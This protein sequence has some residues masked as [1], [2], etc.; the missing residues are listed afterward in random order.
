MD[1]G[2]QGKRAIVT[3]A[4]R[5]IGRAIAS[6][7]A[8]EG[9]DVAI[10]A[11][12]KEAVDQTAAA[13]ARSGVKATGG[14]VDVADLAALRRWIGEAAE[15]LGGLDIFVANVSALAQGM[16]EDSWRK[17]FEIDVM[18]TVFGIEAALPLLEKSSAGSIVVVGSTAMA[19]VYGPTRSYAAV[20]AT[21][22]P[23]VKGLA[24]NLAAKNVRANVVSPGNVYFQGGVW[25]LVEQR[26]P[27]MFASMLARNPTGRMGTPE[28]VANAVVFLASP[29]A[30]F[31]TGTNLIIDGALTQRVQF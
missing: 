17:G 21:L 18:G 2:L 8:A 20:K 24:R 28:E 7:L 3:G 29:R 23:Y 5:G 15:T 30:S 27:E 26:N 4:T 12:H 11:R 25:N 1:L 6:L 14:A 22:I 16:D 19:E 13:L 10:C 9:C 31:I